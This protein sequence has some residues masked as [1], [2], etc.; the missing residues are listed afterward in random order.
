[1]EIGS[2]IGIVIGCGIGAMIV[3]YLV[4]KWTLITKIIVP[5]AYIAATVGS[6]C[7]YMGRYDFSWQF[8]LLVAVLFTSVMLLP[9]F[10]YLRAFLI[11][12]F[13]TL[14][15]SVRRLAEGDLTRKCDLTSVDEFG[16]MGGQINIMIDNLQ[17][18]MG[19]IK[20][21]AADTNTLAASLSEAVEMTSSSS[22]Q[23]GVTVQEIARSAQEL[24]RNANSASSNSEQAKVASEKGAALAGSMK[25]RIGSIKNATSASAEQ[26]QLLGERSQ[27]ITEIIETINAIS[28][29][30]NLLALNA[31]IEAAR[32]G[33]AGRGFAVVADEV[34]KLAEE[35]QKAT[36][37]IDALVKSIQEGI[38][39]SVTTITDNSESVAVGIGS[40]DQTLESFKEIPSLVQGVKKSISDVS[41]I[42]EENAAGAEEVSASVQ[43]VNA[44]M[45][46]AAAT[47]K[48]MA[49]AASVLQDLTTRFTLA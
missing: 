14:G 7:L 12:P 28:E 42:A 21:N 3:T 6:I 19:M 23:V 49:N 17:D 9:L 30:T 36:A 45:Q 4:F 2:A 33:D 18:M 29:Q 10:F 20:Q 40:L 25:E 43:E 39:M 1:M 31:A 32:A 37:E 5:M 15:E 47:A 38:T 44:A 8:S 27:R 26:V 41:A 46:T 13:G 22:E 16:V 11:K 35:S 48:K 34:R 24:S